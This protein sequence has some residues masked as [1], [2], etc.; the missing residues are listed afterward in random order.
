[1]P[2]SF[3][4]VTGEIRREPSEDKGTQAQADA[5]KP[6]DDVAG[7][8]ECTLRLLDERRERLCAH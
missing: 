7:Q 4:E 1:M 6:A 2:I 3:E 5:P 8:I